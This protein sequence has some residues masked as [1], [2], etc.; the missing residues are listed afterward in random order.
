MTRPRPRSSCIR[1]ASGRCRSRRGRCVCSCRASTSRRTLRPRRCPCAAPSWTRSSGSR[2]QL[3]SAEAFELQSFQGLRPSAVGAAEMSVSRDGTVRPARRSLP[4]RFLSRGLR[5]GRGGSSRG[6]GVPG[7]EEERGRRDHARALR[8]LGSEAGPGGTRAGEARLHGGGGGGERDGEP[9]PG[10]AAAGSLAGGSRAAAHDA[11][12][13]ARGEVRGSVPDEPAWPL[14]VSPA[15]AAS[16][17]GGSVPRGAGGLGVRSGECP[18]LLRGPDG[19]VDGLLVGGGVRAGAGVGGARWGWCAP[20]PRVLPS[21]RSRRGSPPSRR[22]GSTSRGFWRLRTS[23]CGTRWCRGRSG[24]RASRCRVWTR[25][26]RTRRGWWCT[27]RAGRSRG[28]TAD[29]HVRLSVNGGFVGEATFAGKQPYRL[30]VLVP[31][32]LLREGANELAV[33]NV[34]DTGV[35]SLVFLDRFEVSYPQASTVR[36][37]VFEGVWAE[38]G[39]MEVA[40]LSG[41]PVILRDTRLPGPEGSAVQWVD[42]LP[43]DGLGRCASRRRRAIGM[44]SSPPKGCSR[45]GSDGCLSRRSRGGRTRRTTW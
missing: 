40:G 43:D 44:W 36:A 13:S 5:A 37:G 20:S 25:L 3:V 24:R 11:A 10:A 26:P 34:G 2:S 33:A 29:H 6:D 19:D 1:G 18:V 21:S 14:D 42:R 27:C 38:S 41:P 17:G 9:G 22:T 7:G 30:D 8:R 39:T 15:P 4:P 31:A 28:S 23:G 35:S 32:S 12:G 45:P 16:G